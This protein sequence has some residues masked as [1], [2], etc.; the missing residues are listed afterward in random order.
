MA[1]QHAYEG[2]VYVLPNT[3]HQLL[4]TDGVATFHSGG[5]P[6][7]AVSPVGDLLQRPTAKL[8]L[9]LSQ[10]PSMDQHKQVTLANLVTANPTLYPSRKAASP[11]YSI[12]K[13]QNLMVEHLPLALARYNLAI[14]AG[15]TASS[16]FALRSSI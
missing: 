11:T 14:F 7:S 13:R 15:E 10:F 2:K 4:L 12:V 3:V 8:Q 1:V 9:S 16:S 6:A 5:T